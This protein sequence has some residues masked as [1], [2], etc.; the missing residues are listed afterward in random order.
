MTEWHYSGVPKT[1]TLIA[2][3]VVGASAVCLVGCA[4]SASVSPD[5]AWSSRMVSLLSAPMDQGGGGGAFSAESRTGTVILSSV[6]AGSYDVLAVCTGM[7]MVRLTVSS[8]D[9]SEAGSPP[10]G[11]LASADILCGA[12]LRLPV[13]IPA[14][15]VALT[16]RSTGGFG[17]WESAIVASG[18]SPVPTTF[19]R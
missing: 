16:V 11:T 17:A 4:P 8:R 9:R 12:T 18:W 15:G 10:N 3:L 14:G 13:E 19:A 6:A 1:Q 2:W 7:D 5:S